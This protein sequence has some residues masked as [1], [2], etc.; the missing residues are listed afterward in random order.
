MLSHIR[1]H[2]QIDYGAVMKEPKALRFYQTLVE[3]KPAGR[4][5]KEPPGKPP[6]EP[7]RDNEFMDVQEVAS[8]LHVKRSTIYQW[9]SSK[10]LPCYKFGRLIRIRKRDLQ[11]WVEKHR[12]EDD[13]QEE[14]RIKEIFQSLQRPVLDIDQLVQRCIEEEKR[15]GYTATLE[16]PGKDKGL[17]KE[18]EYGS[19]S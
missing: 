14:R 17:G 18:G 7:N 9:T 6:A 11:E 16:K 19:L 5:K 8:Y 4:T 15:K 3:K 1:L 12:L 13:H 2:D 10:T